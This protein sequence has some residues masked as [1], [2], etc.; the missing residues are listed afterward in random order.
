MKI[1]F[2]LLMIVF[3]ISCKST[4]STKKNQLDISEA[5]TEFSKNKIQLSKIDLDSREITFI[6]ADPK[7]ET[8]FTDEKGKTQTFKNVS[9]V[10]ISNK[11]EIKKDSIVA[12][13]KKK[14]EKKD[15]K[16]IINETAI[17]TSDAKNFKAMF[18][19][20]FLIVLIIFIGYLIYKFKK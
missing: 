1:A 2:K 15:D 19:Y 12:S 10:K 18:F 20:S 17:A 6:V 5:K 3:L 4:E 13:D 9:S 7:E 14:S 11:K 8:T 16:S